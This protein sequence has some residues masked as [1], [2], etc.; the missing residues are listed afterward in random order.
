MEGE[1]VAVP[2]PVVRHDYG[3]MSLRAP[4]CLAEGVKQQEK[5]QLSFTKLP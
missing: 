5:R 3:R 4:R 2:G 1:V